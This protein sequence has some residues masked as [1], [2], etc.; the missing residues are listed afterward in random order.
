MG[1]LSIIRKQKIK[2]REIRVL[3][4][5]LDNSGKTT[6]IN[7]LL[8][9]D[10]MKVAP[11]MGFQ[12]HTF[13]WKNFTLNVWDIGGQSTLRSFWGNYFDK[14]DVVVW[15]VD[16][17]NTSRLEELYQELREKVIKQDQLRG[18][19]FVV[20]VNKADLIEELERSNV[21]AAILS[22][23]KLQQEVS[24]TKYTIC[25]VLGITGEGLDQSMDWIVENCGVYL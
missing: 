5:G 6:I 19:L 4:L 24:A 25:S 11:T 12:I 15:V 22:A 14:L 9:K 1:L 10:P 23:L 13:S 17:V 21:C 3:V 7:N 18:T 2:D 8:G 20:M 16:S